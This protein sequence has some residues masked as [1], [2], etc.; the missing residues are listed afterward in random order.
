MTSIQEKNTRLANQLGLT[1]A[2]LRCLL[3]LGTDKGLN[4]TKVG[5]RMHLSLSRVTR[6]IDGLEEKEFLPEDVIVMIERC[7]KF[8]VNQ[9]REV[10]FTEIKKTKY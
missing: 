9:K 10:G 7:S 6:I 5:M 3:S 1:E 2:E 8:D 4:N